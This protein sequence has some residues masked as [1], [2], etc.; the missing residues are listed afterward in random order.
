MKRRSFLQ[1]LPPALTSPA[2]FRLP[3]LVLAVAEKGP[4]RGWAGLRFSRVEQSRDP[5]RELLT[6][7]RKAS[8]GD[9]FL[10]M[11]L[12]GRNY[13]SG[14]FGAWRLGEGPGEGPRQRG[15]DEYSR[16]AGEAEEFLRKAAG[17]VFVC[18]NGETGIKPEANR[19]LWRVSFDPPEFRVEW[20][21]AV[22][23]RL[24]E[25]GVRLA[26]VFPTLMQVATAPVMPGETD[27]ESLWPLLTGERDR[28]P[29][30]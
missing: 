24:V 25:S 20:P 3:E 1:L 9:L 26:D 13:R 10:P 21:G 23:E 19:M 17:A 16:R 22:A 27:G 18:V 28:L 4:V 2:D 11:A 5:W 30:R 29:G 14:F 8:E 15:Y 12:K 7:R 6:G